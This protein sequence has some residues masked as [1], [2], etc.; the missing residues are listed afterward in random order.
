VPTVLKLADLGAKAVAVE[1]EKQGNL[2]KNTPRQAH[3]TEITCYS[4]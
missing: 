2:F 4:E 1:K 3:R